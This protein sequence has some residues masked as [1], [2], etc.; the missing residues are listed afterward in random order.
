[1]PVSSME[2]QN[3]LERCKE[4]TYELYT[5]NTPPEWLV[6]KRKGKKLPVL[7]EE[8][9]KAFKSMS[10]TKAAGSDEV[11]IELLEAL[12]DFGA[13]WI[14]K[15]S[16]KRFYEQHFPTDMVPS[17]SYFATESWYNKL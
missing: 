4:Y 5:N 3:L 14:T 1:M 2:K 16:K 11:Y 8:I 13:D 7:K 12:D 10:K 6:V 17:V 15:I 9:V